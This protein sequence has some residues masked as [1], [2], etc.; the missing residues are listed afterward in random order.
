MHPAPPGRPGDRRALLAG[1]LAAAVLARPGRAGAAEG[2]LRPDPAGAPHRGAAAAAGALVWLH[3]YHREGDPPPPPPGILAMAGMAGWDL[4]RQDRPARID[5][6]APAAA[7]LAVGTAGLRRAGYRQV[8]LAGESRGAFVALVALRAAGLADAALFLAPAAHGTRPERRAEALADFRAA[9]AAM[10]PD[11]LRRAALV[12]FRDDP[13]D[14]DTAARAAAFA[15][16]MAARGVPALVVDRP[17]APVGHGG[18]WDP[19]FAPRFA[20]CL[21]GFLAGTAGAAACQAA[22]AGRPG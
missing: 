21:A 16:A 3:A 5:P 6:L 20:P 11:A 13:Y 14:P 18:A 22:L 7:S 8:V 19:D 2:A 12:L 1:L 4:W 9:L 15:A 17:D 10:A